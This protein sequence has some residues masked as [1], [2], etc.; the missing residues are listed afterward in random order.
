M[1]FLW[2]SSIAK[3]QRI[4]LDLMHS[5]W[6]ETYTDMYSRIND[7]KKGYQSTSNL[8]KDKNGDLLAD[9]HNILNSW[10]NYFAQLLNVHKDSDVR[11]IKIKQLS[12]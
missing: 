7:F 6:G 10:K 11:K 3:T 4:S 12:R 5:V 2:P 8:V 9:S 1:L